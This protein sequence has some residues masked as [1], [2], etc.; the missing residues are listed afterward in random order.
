M[1]CTVLVVSIDCLRQRAS[2]NVLEPGVIGATRRP[3]PLASLQ[4]PLSSLQ[5]PLSSLQESLSSLR[6][7]IIS[8][9]D[10]AAIDGTYLWQ[11]ELTA[12]ILA[13]WSGVPLA[14]IFSIRSEV[15]RKC[16]R[17]FTASVIS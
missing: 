6:A 15:K 12:T 11:M 9:N 2:N 14:L 4:E 7:S 10:S 5:E 17:W 3:Q 8:Y 1:L 16:A 13:F